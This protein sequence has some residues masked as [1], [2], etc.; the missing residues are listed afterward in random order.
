MTCGI[1]RAKANSHIYFALTNFYKHLVILEIL[2]Q[3]IDRN[4]SKNILQ[5]YINFSQNIH[6]YR[7]ISVILLI[8]IFYYIAHVMFL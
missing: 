4:M 8:Y 1:L 7:N 6:L 2:F 5:K 3:L